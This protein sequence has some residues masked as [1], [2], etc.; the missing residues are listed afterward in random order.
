MGIN[1]AI[2]NAST[3]IVRAGCRPQ[4]RCF[5]SVHEFPTQPS[6][7]LS[8]Q[9]AAPTSLSPNFLPCAAERFAGGDVSGLGGLSQKLRWS[10]PRGEV[11]NKDLH[12][13][14]A[15]PDSIYSGVACLGRCNG[16]VPH[17]C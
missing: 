3:T 4:A 14:E 9:V 11:A 7:R 15:D 6:A 10:W 8:L 2:G 5:W 1:L 17:A 13:A 16:Q 12:N